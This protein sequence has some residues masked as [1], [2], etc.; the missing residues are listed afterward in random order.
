MASGQQQVRDIKNYSSPEPG[1]SVKRQSGCI[2]NG[3]S[4]HST[5]QVLFQVIGRGGGNKEML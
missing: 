5:V 4:K 2:V 1:S 3:N